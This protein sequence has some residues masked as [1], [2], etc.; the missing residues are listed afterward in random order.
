[1]T[2]VT[3]VIFPDDL[4]LRRMA[5]PSP[6]ER[7]LFYVDQDWRIAFELD[8]DWRSFTVFAG[9][10]TDLAS[11]PSVIPKWVAQKVD[12]HIEAAVAHDAMYVAAAFSKEIA[13]AV[14]LR[15][16]EESGVPAWR[17]A[18]MY[19]AVRWFGKGNYR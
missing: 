11:I 4:V 16:M 6:K 2:S 18:V 9:F 5:N 8:G 12:A 13:D 3:R 7:R 19:R 14:F 17:R 10:F 1:M 15:A